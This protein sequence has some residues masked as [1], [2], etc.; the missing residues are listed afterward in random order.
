MTP[1]LLLPSVKRF[2]I[3]SFIGEKAEDFSNNSIQLIEGDSIY[4][5]TD[6]YA[7]QFGGDTGK[8][9]MTK[10][11]KDLFISIADLNADEQEIRIDEAFNDWKKS[12]EQVDDVLL[13]GIKV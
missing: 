12:F 2:P 1:P 3:G 10:N 11:L 9:F 4:V 6:G 13:I 5:F 8:K 7:D